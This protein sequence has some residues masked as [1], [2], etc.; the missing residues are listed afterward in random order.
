MITVIFVSIVLTIL[1]TSFIRI[2]VN[3]R[4]ESTDNDLTTR[5]FYAAE[6]GVQDAVAAI[7][8]GSLKNE[9]ECTPTGGPGS[10][11]LADNLDT[12]YT[13]QIVEMS[14]SDYQADLA[15]NQT[16]MLHLNVGK[17][18]N[19]LEFKWHLVDKN[20]FALRKSSDDTLPQES[21]WRSK[22][23]PFPAM[24]QV[25]VIEL[26]KSG[27][28]RDNI[29]NFMKFISPANGGAGG[30][31][32]NLADGSILAANCDPKASTGTYACVYN[33][34]GWDVDAKDYYVRVTALYR[35]TQLKIQAYNGAEAVP[36]IGVQAAVDVTGRAGDVYRRVKTRVD[37]S[38]PSLLPNYAIISG[39]GICKNFLI[40]DSTDDAVKGF[41]TINPGI[42][43]S[44][45]R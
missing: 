31:A 19:K 11:K 39:K 3:E 41:D 2:T 5:A 17:P 27:V 37:L 43:G 38:P 25:E 35:S 40:T 34:T 6:A 16:V 44:C 32:Y 8:K 1:V 9:K 24:L 28:S 7:K 20:Q 14:P 12:E 29:K 21:A 45:N 33:L 4:R 22:G 36:L 13:C 15:K 26:P 23:K 10:G 30:S 18:I 42:D